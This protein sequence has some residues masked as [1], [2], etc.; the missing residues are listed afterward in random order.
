MIW[1]SVAYEAYNTTTAPIAGDRIVNPK[2]EMV[3]A[4]RL[5]EAVI[6]HIFIALVAIIRAPTEQFF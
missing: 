3:K 5:I 2:L 1:R 4:Y 6:Y